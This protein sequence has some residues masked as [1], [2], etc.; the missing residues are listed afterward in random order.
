MADVKARYPL[1]AARVEVIP[2]PGKPGSF[3]AALQLMPHYQ[4]EDIQANLT[5]VT[6][7]AAPNR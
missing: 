4:L 2:E 6:Q 1:Y 7:L 5:L 3:Q